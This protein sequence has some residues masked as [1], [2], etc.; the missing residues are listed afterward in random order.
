VLFLISGPIMECSDNPTS[1]NKASYASLQVICCS[2]Q[3][4]SIRRDLFFLFFYR[5]FI[6][7]EISPIP[8]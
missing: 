3:R 7:I 6:G 4:F 1:F 8:I 2:T 5:L